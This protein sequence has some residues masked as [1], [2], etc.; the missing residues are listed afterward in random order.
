MKG[1]ERIRELGPDYYRIE[2]EFGAAA[3]FPPHHIPRWTEQ[4]PI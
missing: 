3:R 4:L 1:L 2:L